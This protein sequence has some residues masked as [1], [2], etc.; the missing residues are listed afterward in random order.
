MS[1]RFLI[2]GKLLPCESQLNHHPLVPF[3]I[4]QKMAMQEN[5]AAFLKVCARDGLAPQD[6]RDRGASPTG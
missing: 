4:D 2:C 1:L 5:A 3:V 6:D